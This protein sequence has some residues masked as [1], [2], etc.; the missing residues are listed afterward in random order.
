MENYCFMFN[1]SIWSVF[2]T[3][4]LLLSSNNILS[5]QEYANVWSRA[6]KLENVEEIA[7]YFDNR[8]EVSI[9]DKENIFSKE[10]AQIV[11]KDF[12][13]K[14][15]VSG[16][17]MIHNGTSVASTKYYIGLLQTDIGTIRTYL[18]VREEKGKAIIQEIHFD[19]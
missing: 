12:F 7:K 13:S 14:C 1:R 15:V 17:E 9:F 8:V 18:L 3:F 6:L 19:E 10:Q 2:L 5:A 11:L 4:T 16:F